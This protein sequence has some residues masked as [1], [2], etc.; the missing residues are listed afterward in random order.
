MKELVI[1]SGKGGTGKTTLTASFAALSGDKI[2]ADCDVD[3]ADLHLLLKPAILKEEKFVSSQVA[4][5]D[6]ESCLACDICRTVCRFEAISE[7][8]VVNPMDCEGCRL[9]ERM[10]PIEVIHMEKQE[11]GKWYIAETEFGPMVFA[12]LGVAEENSGQL[13]SLVRREAQKLAK[14]KNLNYIIIDGPPGVGC[15]VNS[16]ITG[17]QLAVIVTEPTMSGIH[18]LKRILEL[19]RQFRVPALVVVNK[20]DLNLEN[21]EQIEAYC[22]ERRVE[23][24]GKIPF[25]TSVIKA[26]QAGEILVH[27]SGDGKISRIVTDIWEKVF[28]HLNRL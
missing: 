26:L 13:V 17:T 2:M 25:D 22:R 9:C 7:D 10:C 16:A 15:P 6:R 5:I 3:A 28:S 1:V 21:T 20:F 14:E 8:Y 27:F 19:T 23:L 24:I 12:Q 11:N 4:V 18:D